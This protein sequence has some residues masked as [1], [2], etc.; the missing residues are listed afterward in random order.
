M[1]SVASL[2]MSPATNYLEVTEIVGEPITATQL[3][4][5][6][7]RYFWAAEQCRGLDA[8]EAGCGTGPGLGML[9]HAA[10]S[11]EAGD[12]SP[13]IVEIARRHYGN[14][15][16]ITQFDA[17]QMP[18]ADRSKDVVMLFEAIYYV[19]DAHRFVAECARILRPGGR[20]LIVTAN[21]DQW[22]FHPSAHSVRYYGVT[23][24][25]QMFTKH[26]FTCRFSA[27]EAVDSVDLRQRVLRPVKKLAVMSGLMPKS[28]AG[29]R[30]LKRIVF[31]RQAPMPAEIAA[32][33][34]PY[35]PPQEIPENTPDRLH[36]IIY[37]VATRAASA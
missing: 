13:A 6:H 11:F 18:F 10:R 23:E 32:G 37:C 14:R 29:K 30:W 1:P 2:P 19:P 36:R 12:F 25:D 21:K 34:A 8:V 5:L 26:G 31:G 28:M 33:A 22:D 27:I 15:F 24:L 9:A 20:V 3:A 16:P 4:R 17:Q 7:H 35:E